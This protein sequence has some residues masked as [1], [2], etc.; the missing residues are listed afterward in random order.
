MEQVVASSE[1]PMVNQ[2]EFSSASD[3]SDRFSRRVYME[4]THVKHKDTIPQ[5]DL[6]SIT[7]K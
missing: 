5:L 1:Q 4:E 2:Q 7:V 6:S 3:A